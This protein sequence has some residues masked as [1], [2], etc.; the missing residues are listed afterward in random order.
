[1]WFLTN[2]KVGFQNFE[3]W[4]SDP[5]FHRN[6]DVNDAE[7]LRP[8][9]QINLMYNVAGRVTLNLNSA[10]GGCWPHWSVSLVGCPWYQSCGL[11]GPEAEALEGA[12]E[13]SVVQVYAGQGA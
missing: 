12:P 5:H 3:V 11:K 1:M 4:V 9:H 2:E 10:C 7:F 8:L 6:P 13:P